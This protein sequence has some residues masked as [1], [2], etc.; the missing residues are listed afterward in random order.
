MEIRSHLQDFITILLKTSK[1]LD[2]IVVVVEKLSKKTHFVT[3]KSTQK[4]IDIAQ[5]FMKEILKLHGISK[6]IILYWDAKFSSFFWKALFV[7]FG[8]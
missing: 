8:T 5:V 4:S 7:G 1:K 3:I 2:A 6:K